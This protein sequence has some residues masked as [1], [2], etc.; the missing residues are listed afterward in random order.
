M[1]K[2]VVYGAT[3]NLYYEML[4]AAK[5]LLWHT[6]VDK[7]YF[8]TEDDEFPIEVPDC[9][10]IVNVK[11]Q[12]YFGKQCRNLNCYWTYM[13]L[14]KATYPLLFPDTDKILSLD[15]DTIVMDDISYLWEIP[16]DDYYFAGVVEPE[17][18]EPG[19]NYI[20][21]GVMM[22]NCEKLRQ[23]KK[24]DQIIS[25]LN[26]YFYTFPEQEV[27][28][29]LCQNGL[30]ILPSAY[31][32]AVCT[33]IV[34]KPI[35]KHFAAM[36]NYHQQ[37]LFKMADREIEDIEKRWEKK[38]L[39][40]SNRPLGRCENITAV[41]DAYDGFKQFTI[42]DVHRTSEAIHQGDYDLIISDEFVSESAAPV[43]MIEHGAWG[44]K[45]GGFDIPDRYI[46]LEDTELLAYVITTSKHEEP[47]QSMA[48]MCGVDTSQVLSYGMPRFDAYR[49]KGKRKSK[50]KTYLYVPTFRN[51]WDELPDIDLE[52]ISR[53]L[54]DGETFVVKPHMCQDIGK[55]VLWPHIR[56]ASNEEPS[57]N[58]LVNADVVIT[59]YSS[60]MCDAMALKKPVVL[61][62]KD[63]ES[64][65]ENRGMYYSYP[66]S[67]SDYHCRTE[68]DL[69]KL[70]RTAEWTEKDDSRRDF[71]V[72][73][74]DG[75][76]TK[77]VV[78]L[79]NRLLEREN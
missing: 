13:A 55:K 50:K 16:M 39:F 28:N 73:A 12:Q 20:N 61:F 22:M 71:F 26:N 78:D 52:K 36:R 21:A 67:Y 72:G 18:C 3:R 48:N 41:W 51:L 8:L 30:Y 33:E 64:Y 63:Y 75:K 35:I 79:I 56:F 53:L 32:Q 42:L 11:D 15:V 45:T 66:D 57:F 9:V 44:C 7:I 68:E 62:E 5:S 17:K 23:D 65:K 29:K 77:R 31:N 70:C 40:T 1:K 43:I 58:E 38:V 4:V 76:S 2:I 69:V 27:I 74:C 6:K 14:M 34:D 59:D 49:N 47:I 19:F 37:S 60:I 25:E 24:V 46:T 10:E 54:K